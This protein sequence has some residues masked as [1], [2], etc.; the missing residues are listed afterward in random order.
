MILTGAVN[1]EYISSINF[2]DQ[3]EILESVLDT[4]SEDATILDIMEKTGRMVQTDM[5]TYTG[6]TNDYVFISGTISAIDATDNGE[7]VAGPTNENLV[8]TLATEEQLPIVGEL[9]LL[10][11]GRQGR[12]G[13]VNKTTRVVTITPFSNLAADTLSPVGGAVATSQKVSFFSGAYGEGSDRSEGKK[14][15]F[16]RTENQIQIFKTYREVTDLQKASPTEVKFDGKPF[17]LYKMQHDVLMEHRGKI[18]FQFLV[19]K[20]AKYKDADGNDVYQTQG[21]RQSILNGDGTVLTS[22]GLNIPLAAAITKANFRT[23]SRGLD[24]RGAGP[25]Y[26]LWAG[27]DIDADIDDM[28]LAENALTAGGVSYNSWGQGDGKK[29][30]IDLGVSSFRLY[31]R[32]F[33]KKKLV[34]YD[35]QEVFA[36]VPYAGEAYLIPTGK[37]KT[38]HSGASV[39]AIRTRF[40]ANDGTDFGKYQENLSG[41]IA[42]KGDTKSV[43]GVDYLSVMGL[44]VLGVRQFGIFSK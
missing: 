13:A 42:G 22:G 35:H 17:V 10:Q 18:A 12:V 6:F 31:N 27:G 41:R 40:M 23:M 4:T 34:A 29:R 33:H 14:P 28:L 2:L 39:D 38:N 15:R 19:G 7:A 25:E 32:T 24:K 44:E 37:V 43:L 8:I 1:K 11:N 5:P 30:A 20:K 26:W 36:H 3:R 9:A 16:I 21:L